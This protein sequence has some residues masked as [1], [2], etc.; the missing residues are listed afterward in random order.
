VAGLR[1]PF[2]TT[3]AWL[4]GSIAVIMASHSSKVAGESSGCKRPE[5]LRAECSD[6]TKQGMAMVSEPQPVSIL[7]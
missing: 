7:Q 5:G 3:T 1:K 4:G 2:A 6:G